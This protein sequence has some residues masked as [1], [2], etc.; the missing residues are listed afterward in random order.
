M[1]RYVYIKKGYTFLFGLIDIVG[2]FIRAVLKIILPAISKAPGEVKR[3]VIIELAHLGDLL[4][5]TPALRLLRKRF[6]RAQITVVVSPWSKGVITKNPDID[7]VILYRASWFDRIEKKRFS[8]KET[9]SFIR[10]LRRGDFDLGIDMRCDVRVILLLWLGRVR[11][12]VGYG[13]TGGG[14]LLSQVV[15]FDVKKRQDRHQIDHNIN[16]VKAIGPGRKIDSVDKRM[17]L[18]FSSADKRYIE[19]YLKANSITEKDFLIAIHLGTGLPSKSWPVEKFDL[20]VD[21]ILEKYKVKI[22]LVG[23]PQEVH[24]G[25]K[26]AS[27][28]D[29][30]VVNSIG[31]TSIKQLAALLKRCRLFIGGD[32]GLMHI[33]SAAE[34]PIVAIWSGQAKPSLWRPLSEEDIVIDKPLKA[35]SAADVLDGVSRQMKRLEKS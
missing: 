17:A 6:P 5:T 20:L 30:N 26:V 2:Y 28:K 34:I 23:G 1:R 7:E 29:A 3:I 19:E 24:L 35:I 21:K 10:T 16:L 32:S 15:P 25:E 12:R 27:S 31:R 18:Y 33:A 14:F 22:I 11:Y 13:F 4:V 9:L 8:L